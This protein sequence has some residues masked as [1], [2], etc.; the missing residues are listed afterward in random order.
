M[1]GT[2][3]RK[4]FAKAR[5]YDFRTCYFKA[6]IARYECNESKATEVAVSKSETILFNAKTFEALL[7]NWV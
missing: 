1:T 6:A 4:I 2:A 5:V 3:F 7:L